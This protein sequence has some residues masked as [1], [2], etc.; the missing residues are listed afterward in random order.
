MAI[1]KNRIKYIHSLELKKKRKEENVFLAEGPKLVEDLL[2]HF[3]C[4]FLMGTR[5]WLAS[6]KNLTDIQDITEVT[7]EE[8]ARASLQKTPQQ[9]LAVLVF[10]HRLGQ[11][12]QLRPVDPPLSVSD[13]FRTGHLQPLPFFYAIIYYDY[14]TK[15]C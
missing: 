2:G 12:V 8:L 15:K 14:T 6:Q 7:E 11:P 5:E 3:D 1:S 10:E 9:V 13:L 4:R